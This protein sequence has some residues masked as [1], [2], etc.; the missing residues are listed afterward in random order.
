MK[1]TWPC[2]L[3]DLRFEDLYNHR[4]ISSNTEVGLYPMAKAH[5]LKCDLLLNLDWKRKDDK[6]EMW[7]R[8][9]MLCRTN[10]FSF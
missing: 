8:G 10:I 2:D 7:R 1:G 6:S 4:I 5:Y 3:D 9:E